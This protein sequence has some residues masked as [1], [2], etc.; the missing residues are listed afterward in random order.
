MTRLLATALLATLAWAQT[1]PA[2]EKAPQE[3][4]QALRARIEEFY[5]Y[6]VTQE[7]RKAEKLIAEDSQDWFYNH[8]K[9]HYLSIEIQSITFSEHFTRARANVLT[10]QY[11]M[12]PGFAGKPMKMPTT[13]T[14][15]IVD[16]QWFW[17]VDPEEM[18]RT[19]FGVMRDTSS[20]SAAPGSL[21][22]S[23]PTTTD[24]AM[25]FVKAETQ[26][27]KVKAGETAQVAITNTARGPMNLAI[28]DRPAGVEAS[29]DRDLLDAGGKAVLTVKAAPGA[30]AGTIA[31][32]V[33]QTREL[34]PIS[35]AI[36]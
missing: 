17:Y 24:F 33:V 26:S 19:P 29:L 11:V 2:A 32:R 27:L 21:P 31:L 3:V 13:S 20:A 16:G 18:R 9:P 28:E 4:E 12:F 14:W 8:N 15:K 30:K 6:F 10:E 5:H 35:I 22:S 23:I 36:Q 1:P 7:F 25:H 34:I